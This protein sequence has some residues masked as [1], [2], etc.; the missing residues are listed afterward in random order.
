[1]AT[2][3]PPKVLKNVCP[4]DCPDTC[5]MVVTI[6]DGRAVDLRGDKDHPFTRGFLC[7]KMAHYLERVYSDDRLLYPIRR[8]GP[9]GPGRGRFERISWD[10][11]LRIIIDRFRSIAESEHGPQAILPYSYYGTM[12]KIQAESLDRRFFHRLGASKL[13]RTI[14]STAGMA[15]Y[16]YTLGRGRLGADPLAASKCRLLI[17]WGSNTVHTNGHLWSRMVEARNRLGAQIVTIDPY[18][19]PTARRSDWHLQPRPGTDGAL[20]LGIMHVIWRDELQDQDFLDRGTIGAPELRDRVLND[21]DPKTVGA[22]CHLKVEEI[23]SLAKTYATTHPSLIRVNYGLQRHGGGGM[24]VR[25]ITCLPSIVG[26]WRHHGGGVLLSTS[27]TYQLNEARI[28]RPDLAPAGTRTINMNQLAEALHGELPGPPIEALYV[29][30]CNPAAVAP[31]QSKVINGLL[32]DDLFTVVHEQFPTDTVDYADLVLPATT[33]LEHQDIHTSYGHHFVM[34][35]PASIAPPG[36]C[37]SNAEVFRAMANLLGFD[38]SLFPDDETL[39]R[40]VL[41]SSPVMEGI[42]LDQLKREGSVRLRL[43][44]EYLPFVEGDFPT[45]SGKSELYSESMATEQFDPLPVFRPPHESPEGAPELASKYP[46]QLLS[47]PRSQFLNSTFANSARHCR[48]AGGPTVELHPTDAGSRGLVDGDS[49]VVFNDRGRFYAI[50]KLSNAVSLGVATSAGIYWNK[51]VDGGSN[52]N[53]TTST[54]LSDLGG[55]ATF[56]DNLVEIRKRLI[57]N[58]R[59]GA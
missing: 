33:Q 5:S 54:A 25:T 26:A 52:V 2:D 18:Q 15:G 48:S 21:Y 27:G 30:N 45:P 36:E 53:A 11:A 42:T 29:Y 46:L 56:F 6:K 47:P 57:D 32:R 12:G 24:A 34:H 40:E 38:Q 44:E 13:D 55:G 1:M 10:Q 22:I 20:A 14:C 31:N 58:D 35:N 19:S 9:K 28:T 51:C 23:E 3:A 8:I 41:A 17:N 39:I 50:V 37:R 7:G 43:P 4:L 59:G 49:V 16:T